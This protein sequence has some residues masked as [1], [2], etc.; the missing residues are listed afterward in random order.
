[1][2]RLEHDP[3]HIHRPRQGVHHEPLS[4]AADPLDLGFTQLR[5]RVPMGSMHT[6][7]E[8]EKGL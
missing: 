1:M 4:H 3:V 2:G 5:N 6:G 8:E 7:L